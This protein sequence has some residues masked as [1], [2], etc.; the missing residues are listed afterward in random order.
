MN[1]LY[2]ILA[3]LVALVAGWFTAR[4]SGRKAEQAD[5]LKR[6]VDARDKADESDNEMDKLSNDDIRDRGSKWV[7]NK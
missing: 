2:I 7:R 6:E 4:R 1:Q 5:Q 3:G